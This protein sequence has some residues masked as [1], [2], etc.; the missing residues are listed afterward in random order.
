MTYFVWNI[1]LLVEYETLSLF[2]KMENIV[3]AII[4]NNNLENKKV[5]NV[6]KLLAFL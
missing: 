1:F 6:L 2:W 3:N 5:S 4:K